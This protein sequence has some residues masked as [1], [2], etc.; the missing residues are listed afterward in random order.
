M[1]SKWACVIVHC[2]AVLGRGPEKAFSITET[3]SGWINSK[4]RRRK[5]LRREWPICH[6]PHHL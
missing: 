6:Y 5:Q 4:P 2:S 3:F 1:E